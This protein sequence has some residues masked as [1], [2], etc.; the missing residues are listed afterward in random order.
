M[1]EQPN[2]WNILQL[3]VA[4]SRHRVKLPSAYA[5]EGQSPSCP[6]KPLHAFVTFWGGVRPIGNC[7]PKIVPWPVGP[8]TRTR[9]HCC[10]TGYAAPEKSNCNGGSLPCRSLRSQTHCVHDERFFTLDLR[11]FPIRHDP[12]L[13]FP[14]SISDFIDEYAS[15]SLQLCRLNEFDLIF[16]SFN[17]NGLIPFI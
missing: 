1:G 2:P 17:S 9:P 11:A 4:K 8:D 10:L 5:L 14:F 6:R 3:E 16:A 12:Q 13:R 15:T 7:L